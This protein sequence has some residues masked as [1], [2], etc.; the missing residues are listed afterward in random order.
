MGPEWPDPKTIQRWPGKLGHELRN[1]VDSSISYDFYTGQITSWGFLCNP[2]DERFE[3]NALFKLYLDPDY[4]DYI[5]EAPSTLEARTWYHDY[6]SCLY[7]YIMQYFTDTIP[8]FSR[9]RIEFVFSVPVTWRKNPALLAE[10]EKIIRRAGFGSNPMQRATISLTEAEAA[11]IYASKQSMEKGEVF[12][13]CDAGGGTTD[14]NVLKVDNATRGRM[15][16]NPLSW[17]EGEAIGSTLIDWKVRNMVKERL[18]TVQQHLQGDL[19]TII[20]RMM[21]DKFETFKCSFGSVGMDVPKLFLP[22]P[23]LVPGTDFPHAGIEE[24]KMVITREEL[25]AVFDDQVNKICDLID[26]QLRLVSERHATE[27]ISYLVL[28]GGLG[29]SPYVQS[30]IKARYETAWGG[31]SPGVGELSVLLANEPQL[32]VVHGL[33]MSKIQTTRGGPDMYSLRCCPV[34]FGIVCREIYNPSKHQGED[35]VQ[36]PYD[37]RRW[38]ERQINWI[39]TQGQVVRANTGASQRYRLKIDMGREREPWKTRIVTSELP[40]NQLPTSLKRAGAREICGVEAILNPRDMKRKNRHWYEFGK[41]YNRAEFEVRMIIGTGL[42]FEIWSK[43]GIR[44]RE[45]DEIEVQ[46]EGVEERMPQM[47]PS[48][49]GL[50]IYRW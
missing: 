23:G 6:L 15:E 1:K 36:D 49:Q 34:S 22:V 3:Y 18:A 26:K 7:R 40:V 45:H 20:S 30:R 5:E 17:T 38:A 8:K 42:R 41:E 44:S 2:D 25:Q 10:M 39:I 35:I 13:V 33:V 12:L 48:E 50:T 47:Q 11:A 4:K 46:W 29:S 21:A 24:S 14:L 19:D 31:H 43:D 37:G 9:K 28:S 27:P 16:L 32:T